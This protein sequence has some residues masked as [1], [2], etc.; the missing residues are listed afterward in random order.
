MH[1]ILQVQCTTM[2]IGHEGQ[3]Y[4]V[5]LKKLGEIIKVNTIFLNHVKFKCGLIRSLDKGK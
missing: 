5:I 4:M 2:P 1:I 3:P